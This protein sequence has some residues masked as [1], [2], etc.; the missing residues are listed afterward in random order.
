MKVIIY[1]NNGNAIEKIEELVDAMSVVNGWYGVE[2]VIN[3]GSNPLSIADA[4]KEDNSS[5]PNGY[6]L[7]VFVGIAPIQ[8][9]EAAIER[10]LR[11]L[12]LLAPTDISCGQNVVRGLT[13]KLS[14]KESLKSDFMS[15]INKAA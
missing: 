13:Q 6:R 2:S 11:V 12:I 7:A 8:E 14:D 9:V 10:G 1:G 4:V 5:N 3:T 15:V